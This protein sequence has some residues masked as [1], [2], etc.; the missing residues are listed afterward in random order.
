MT[1][2]MVDLAVTAAAV[3]VVVAT[4]NGDCWCEEA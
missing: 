1:V 3:A 2:V 4:D